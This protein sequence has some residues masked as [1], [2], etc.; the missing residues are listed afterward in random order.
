[1][2]KSRNRNRA[3]HKMISIPVWECSWSFKG[4][5][6]VEAK[7]IN[8]GDATLG[9]VKLDANRRLIQV[10]TNIGHPNIRAAHFSRDHQT[11]TAYVFE[12]IWMTASGYIKE[13]GSEPWDSEEWP[14][15]LAACELI[16]REIRPREGFDPGK[17]Q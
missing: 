11:L 12:M 7:S 4:L 10:G 5:G 14:E 8:L 6:A 15:F 9:V 2:P 16:G 17:V 1:M 13:K 3:T